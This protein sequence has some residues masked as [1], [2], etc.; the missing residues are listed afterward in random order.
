MCLILLLGSTKTNSLAGKLLVRV[1]KQINDFNLEK[2]DKPTDL[3]N[4]FRK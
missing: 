3:A 2:S 1:Y 4:R